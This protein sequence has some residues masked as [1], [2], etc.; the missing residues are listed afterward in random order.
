MSYW[1]P[2]PPDLAHVSLEL[3]DGESK[4]IGSKFKG[5][6]GGFKDA[7]GGGFKD[8]KGI[9][10]GEDAQRAST[11]PTTDHVLI[12]VYIVWTEETP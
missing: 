2:H 9:W 4:A 5:T 11:P 10:S 1:P 8:A 6:G 12:K 7:E 3:S